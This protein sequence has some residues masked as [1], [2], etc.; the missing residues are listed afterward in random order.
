MSKAFEELK[1]SIGQA[2]AIQ[3]GEM[4]G[5][6]TTYVFKPVKRYTN[7]QV[8]KIRNNANMTQSVFASFLGVSP[9][10]V[11]AWEKGTNHPIGSACRLLDILDARK[12]IA[13]ELMLV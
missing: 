10:T 6:K 8:K 12:D 5:R 9:K 4:K 2:I 1:T 3:K 7:V 13:I 11:E